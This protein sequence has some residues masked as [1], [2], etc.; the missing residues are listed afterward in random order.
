MVSIFHAPARR[1][2]RQRGFRSPRD[3]AGSVGIA[4]HIA[5]QRVALPIATR[6]HGRRTFPQSAPRA[7]TTGPAVTLLSAAVYARIQLGWHTSWIQ[8]PR[9]R[10]STERRPTLERSNAA[11]RVTAM[12]THLENVAERPV[13]AATD[14][15]SS[16]GLWARAVGHM[17]A[18]VCGLHGH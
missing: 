7:L 18:A 14:A 16:R 5:R 13:A 8:R 1:A 12:V 4:R 15:A 2:A 9:K 6:G 10:A 3:P 17:Q 11:E